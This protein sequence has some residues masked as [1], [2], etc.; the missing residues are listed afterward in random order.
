MLIRVCIRSNPPIIGFTFTL[1][2]M[3]A[4]PEAVGNRARSQDNPKKALRP[5]TVEGLFS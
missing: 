4:G 5:E 3:V 2:A 1:P